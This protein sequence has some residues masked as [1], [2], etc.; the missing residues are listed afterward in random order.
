MTPVISQFDLITAYG[1]GL[2]A[3]W[4]GLMENRTAIAPTDRFKD[5]NFVSNQ[6]ALVPNLQVE[7]G[8]SRVMAMLRPLLSDLA[9]KL[10]LQTPLILATTVGE[11]EYVEREVLEEKPGEAEQSLPL[12][13]LGK[14]K[15]LLGLTGPGFVISSACASSTAA[16]AHAASMIRHGQAPQVLVVACDAVSEFVY[17]GFSTLQS[18]SETPA[19]PFDANRDGLSLGEAAAWALITSSNS[20]DQNRDAISILGYSSTSDAVHMTAPDRNAYGLSRAIAGACAMAKRNPNEIAFVAAHGTATVYS[21]AM[22]LLAFRAAIS[23]PVP[24]FSTK[25]GTGHTLGAAGLVQFLVAARALSRNIAPP[26]VGLTDP[27]PDAAGWVHSSPKPLTSASIA[28]STNSGFG[29]VNTAILIGRPDQSAPE[30]TSDTTPVG[31]KAITSS[32][33]GDSSDQILLLVGKSVKYLGRMTGEARAALVAARKALLEINPL[34]D[35]T[36]GVVAAGD[37]GYLR[38]HIEYFR[39]YIN[40]GRSMGRGNLFIYTLPTSAASEVAIALDLKGPMLYF[41]SDSSSQRPF[42]TARQ[43]IIDG[44]ADAM[45]ALCTGANVAYCIAVTKKQSTS[46]PAGKSDPPTPAEQPR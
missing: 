39:D 42:V 37:L 18:L 9:G 30:P 28:L 34:T 1:R 36:I 8:E 41:Q 10:D 3:L 16:V 45:L 11:I 35:A 24:I 6:A 13:L 40:C 7:P 4:N 38:A 23:Y 21:D 31:P 43:M 44:E 15:R 20:P 2:D 14:I 5:R 32:L 22:E 26:S 27:D 25:G 33:G 29:G 12:N 19:K 46:H 17:S